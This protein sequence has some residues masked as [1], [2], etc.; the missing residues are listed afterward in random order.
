MKKYPP[1]K[2]IS[3]AVFYHYEID[4]GAIKISIRISRWTLTASSVLDGLQLHTLVQCLFISN[5]QEPALVDM[6]QSYKFCSRDNLML[7]LLS[8]RQCKN[9]P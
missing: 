1:C 5:V 7:T 6:E 9:D 8:S 2:E 3:D 4:S